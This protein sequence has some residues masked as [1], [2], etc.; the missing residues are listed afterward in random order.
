MDES[1][2][3][4]LFAAAA[5]IGQLSNPKW[6]NPTPGEAG[7]PE[8]EENCAAHWAYNFADAMLKERK[9]SQSLT[10]RI[11]GREDKFWKDE[12]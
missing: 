12:S 2:L 4:D 5:L 8:S 6:P 9:R 7:L 3:R 10:I 11:M 1:T